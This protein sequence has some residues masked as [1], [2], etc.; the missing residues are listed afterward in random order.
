MVNGHDS[1]ANGAL[2]PELLGRLFDRHAAALEL[3]ARQWCDAAEDVVQEA[4]IELVGQC[5]P[6]DDALPSDPLRGEPFLLRADCEERGRPEIA[7]Q[8][9][10][11]ASL[12]DPIRTGGRKAIEI[13]WRLAQ[14]VYPADLSAAIAAISRAAGKPSLVS[15]YSDRN[16][17]L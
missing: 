6:P 4:L 12:R 5:R 9:N 13:R 8:A 3:Y 17:L 10:H 11:P 15:F 16:T 1:S 7:A 14:A 2:G